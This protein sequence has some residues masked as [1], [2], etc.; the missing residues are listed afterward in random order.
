MSGVKELRELIERAK[1]R[2]IHQSRRTIVFIDE[3]HRFNRAQQD[4]FLPYVE[5]GD[6]TLI[7]ATTRQGLLTSPMRARFGITAHLDFYSIDEL[8][9]QE[10]QL[11]LIPRAEVGGS[12]QRDVAVRARH[13]RLAHNL[14]DYLS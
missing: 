13:P 7:G 3:L 11:A 1:Q 5:R 4:A 10:V 14:R 2:R 9:G 8:A 12:G 6:V